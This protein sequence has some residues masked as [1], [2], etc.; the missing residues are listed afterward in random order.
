MEPA[1]YQQ[2]VISYNGYL[3]RM[4]DAARNFCEDLQDSNYQEISGVLP[5]L[6][7][8]ITWVNEALE[9][10]VNIG[11]VPVDQLHEFRQII[12]SLHEAL[13]NKD[14]VLLY[15]LLQFDV[16]PLFERLKIKAVEA[17]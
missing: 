8:G 16:I 5:V 7:D 13:E 17:N 4:A 11:R 10:F 1:E 2:I 9:G 6:I 12:H 15:D 14:N 3:E